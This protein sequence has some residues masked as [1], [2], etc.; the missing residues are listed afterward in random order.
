MH[1]HMHTHGCRAIIFQAHGVAT[2]PTAGPHGPMDRLGV[3][4]VLC[5]LLGV[6][7]WAGDRAEPGAEAGVEART[8]ARVRGR[9]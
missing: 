1:T 9:S 5:V 3:G 2:G 6:G 8:E 4:T 7:A